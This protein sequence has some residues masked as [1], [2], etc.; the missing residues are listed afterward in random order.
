MSQ[1]VITAT[2]ASRKDLSVGDKDKDGKVLASLIET[3]LQFSL[4]AIPMIIA[5]FLPAPADWI[6]LAVGGSAAALIATTALVGVSVLLYIDLRARSEGLDLELR[7]T[8]AFDRA[9]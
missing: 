4:A 3:V 8:D 7:A 2:P 6:V 5:V 9:V 1:A